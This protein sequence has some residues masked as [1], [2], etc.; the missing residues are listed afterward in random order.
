MNTKG[1]IINSKVNHRHRVYCNLLCNIV[2]N[3][4][5]REPLR[6]WCDGKGY[7][8]IHFFIPNLRDLNSIYIPHLES[9]TKATSLCEVQIWRSI[10]PDIYSLVNTSLF[11]F[12][13][14]NEFQSIGSYII[15]GIRVNNHSI[16]YKLDEF[17]NWLPV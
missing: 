14:S 7:F 17:R 12:I 10:L 6:T 15:L 11:K 5:V 1:Y 16:F 3:H 8:R 2:I 13:A 9:I 4:K